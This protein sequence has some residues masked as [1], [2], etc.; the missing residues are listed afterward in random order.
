MRRRHPNVS[1]EPQAAVVTDCV[2]ACSDDPDE[3][4]G[5]LARRLEDGYQR[6]DQAALAGHDV[7]AWETFWVKLLREYEHVCA[8]MERAA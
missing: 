3:R 4:L 8:E 5:L 1:A 2:P 7:S 6:I